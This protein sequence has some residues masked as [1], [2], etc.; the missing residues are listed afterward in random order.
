VHPD[1]VLETQAL[2][3]SAGRPVPLST[4]V[5]HGAR[6]AQFLL[7]WSAAIVDLI[8]DGLQDVLVEPRARRWCPA[9]RR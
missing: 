8:R 4:V 5:A 1:Q 9:S 6:L 3:R 7:G 2:A